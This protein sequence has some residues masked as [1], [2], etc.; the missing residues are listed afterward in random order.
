MS[1]YLDLTCV[2]YL[3]VPAI[4]ARAASKLQAAGSRAAI[5]AISCYYS[6][7]SSQLN[8][9]SLALFLF[10]HILRSH[11][12]TK[13]GECKVQHTTTLRP[14][15]QTTN[16]SAPAQPPTLLSPGAQCQA[17]PFELHPTFGTFSDLV[18]R[19]DYHVPHTVEQ[20]VRY[21]SSTAPA[22]PMARDASTTVSAMSTARPSG[23]TTIRAAE[24][25]YHPAILLELNRR[26]T[27]QRAEG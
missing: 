24:G 10:L 27:C 3:Y 2:L 12:T 25:H 16:I 6:V 7:S 11:T 18:H 26:H 19:F 4:A 21:A 20:N 5:K 8:P 9:I 15:I 1:R 23:H 13:C 22:C 17:G 14:E